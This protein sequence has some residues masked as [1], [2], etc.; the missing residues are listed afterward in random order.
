MAERRPLVLVGGQLQELPVGDTL[1]GSGG[2]GSGTIATVSGAA[3]GYLWG[4]D[5]TNGVVRMSASM[6]W[7]KDASNNFVT[8]A[9]GDID[10][11]T[12]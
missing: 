11:G 8:L 4:T 12:F 7:T 2:G 9:V 10:C 1:P 5:G 6:G 3:Q